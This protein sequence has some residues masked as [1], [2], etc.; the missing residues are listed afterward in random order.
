MA[1]KVGSVVLEMNTLSDGFE[2]GVDKAIKK[3]DQMGEK[4]ESEGRRSASSFQGMSGASQ[5]FLGNVMTKVFEKGLET[6]QMYTSGSIDAAANFEKSLISLDIVA[7]RFGESGEKARSSAERLGKELRIGT[8]TAAESLQNLLKSG[9]NLDQ[10]SDLLKRFTNEAITGKSPTITLSQ[11]VANL[12]FAYQT[13]NSAL[14]NLSGISENFSDIEEKGAKVM[15]KKLSAMT[16]AERAQAKYLGMLEVTNLTLGSAEKFQ[17]GYI[18]NQ[19]RMAQT[20]E[21]T[22]IAIGQKLMPIMN[23]FILFQLPRAEALL[24]AISQ[25]DITPVLEALR[26]A[27]EWVANNGDIVNS[28]LAG[29]AAMMAV[30]FGP[31]VW[32]YITATAAAMWGF[33]ASIAPLIPIGL[34]V[35]GLFYAWQNNLGGFQDKVKGLIPNLEAIWK[36]LMTGNFEGG[37]FGLSEDHPFIDFLFDAREAAISLF[38][39]GRLLWTG[40]FRGGIFGLNED[41]PFIDFLFTAREKTIDFVKKAWEFLQDAFIYTKDTLIP[42]LITKFQEFMNW[43]STGPGPII[44]DFLNNVWFV[45]T[46]AFKVFNE[47]ILPVLKDKLNDFINFWNNTLMP[48]LSK[49]WEV[50]KP[51]IDDLRYAFMQIAERV[52]PALKAFSDFFV[53]YIWPTIKAAIEMIV[54]VI[55]WFWENILQPILSVLIPAVIFIAVAAFRMFAGAVKWVVDTAIAFWNTFGS[56]ITQVFRGIFQFL[57]GAMQI[58]TGI[59]TGNGDKVRQGFIN[60]F[61]GIGNIVGGIFRGILNGI[62]SVINSGLGNINGLIDKLPELGGKRVSRLPTL[63]ML[64]KGTNWF[65]GGDAIVGENGPELVRM[66]RGAQV[67]PNK[68]TEAMAQ[69]G[70]STGGKDGITIIFEGITDT[71]EMIGRIKDELA[72]DTKNTYILGTNLGY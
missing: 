49:A 37:I 16:D 42:N 27:M 38:E 58:I 20:I 39:I 24:A 57:Q 72:E 10:A 12:S 23:E 66:P 35:G 53:A 3:M 8:G 18:D 59:F 52:L 65:E 13:G 4:A 40:D 17:G 2:K 41:A 56:S 34:I 64:A 67:I 32:A 51:G 22:R 61:T 70:G 43:W 14:G 48:A 26:T 60:I 50:I 68:V 55:S 30:A 11:A 25:I 29:T 19:I 28:V 71:R 6:F 5:V 7:G 21:E 36:L 54:A 47:T 44:M 69:N 63:P 15:G 1:L 45:L 31:A 33:M 62:I 9:L 46:D